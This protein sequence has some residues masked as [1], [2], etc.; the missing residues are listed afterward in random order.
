[1]T[2][3]EVAGLAG[4][5][6]AYLSIIERGLRPLDRR[7]M[8][9]ALAAALRVS[10][11]DLTGGPHLGTDPLQSGPHA[12]IPALRAALATNSLSAPAASRARPIAQLAAEVAG[13]IEPRRKNCDY[14]GLG[15]LL[16]DVIDE[17]HLQAAGADD[18]GAR[19]E[20]LQALV[21]AC[22][23]AE[24][25]CKALRY[26]DLAHLAAVRAE[27]AA[28]LTGDPVTQGKA[29][30]LRLQTMPRSWGRTLVMAE[31]AADRLEPHASTPLA[32]QVLGIL[33]LSAA[34]AAAAD[35]RGDV[36]DHWLAEADTIARHVTDDMAGNWQSFGASNVAVWRTAV[37]VERGE[38]GG[39]VLALASAVP[40]KKI[41]AASRR[42]DFLTDVG[43]GLASDPR[44]A[45]QAAHYL[46]MGEE[47]APQRFRNY[48]PA[49]EAV[50]F[51]LTR[52]RATPG[53]RELR[54]MASRMG[55]PH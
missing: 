20:A 5:T 17:L 1:M 10:E 4:I 55:V 14:V 37:A 35:Q 44:T 18:E 9:S 29:A 47:A 45:E 8:I 54:G 31:R 24:S 12:A 11:T 39:R 43:R 40:K 26:P 6:A 41:T 51:L 30:F 53:G 50:A 52:A 23:A 28:Q 22:A 15:E 33:I 38:P 2:L 49:R 16:P 19:T 48:A 46:R 7:S 25:M 27:Q 32:R 34:M 42:S 3:A 13:Q 21:E 36:A